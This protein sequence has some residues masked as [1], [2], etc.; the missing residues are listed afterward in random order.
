MRIAL[1]GATGF[2][3]RAL[4]EELT[5]RNHRVVVLS[6]DPER[7]ARTLPLVAAHH[8]VDL[9]RGLIPAAAFDGVDCVV[10]LAG[11]PVSGRWNPDKKAAIRDSRVLGT[12]HLVDSICRLDHRPR[13][14]VSASAIGFYGDRGDEELGEDQGPGGDFL[15]TTS[16]EW[17]TEAGH[18]VDCGLRVASLRIGIVLDASGG[19]LQQMLLPFRL[20]LGGP[21]GDGRQWWSWIHRMDLVRMICT[22]VEDQWE[23]SWNA[24]APHPVRQAEFARS[25][26]WALGRP[27]IVPAP[28]FALRALL[29]EFS[30]EV[31]TSKRVLPDRARSAGFRWQF[32]RL[33]DA[34]ADLLP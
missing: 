17:E 23:G 22:A 14:L 13:A 15:A 21:L 19:A 9:A 34:L 2:V 31:L 26:G 24:T 1:T 30:T 28:A 8:A 29:G 27:A 25:L 11:E 3:G 18:A 33:K 10:H 20:G 4:V 12:R 32:G 16:V 5:A 6:R 7:A